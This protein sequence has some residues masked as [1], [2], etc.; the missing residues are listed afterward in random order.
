MSI[1]YS[2]L[3][4][5]G[6]K[7]RIFNFVSNFFRENNLI[8]IDYAEPYA[9]GAGLALKLLINEYVKTIYINDLDKS[10]FS[11]WKSIIENPIRFCTWIHDVEITVKNWKKYKK[12]QN[13]SE[14]V[15][16][17]ELAKSTFFLNRTNVSG[18]IKGGLI[19][20]YEQAGKYK[21]D[22]RFNKSNLIDRIKK[23]SKF[24]SRIKVSC[25]D[26]VRFIKHIDKKKQ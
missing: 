21:M 11:F 15:D 26:G 7:T 5:P 13:N 12:I 6:G 9:G 8:G 10:I 18:I 16:E 4:Y 17:F 24:K 19:G 14:D 22:V 2:P 20:G 1:F 25:Q 3:R 23:I